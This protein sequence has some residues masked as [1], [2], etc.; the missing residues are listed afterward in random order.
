MS[1]SLSESEFVGGVPIPLSAADREAV[2]DIVADVSNSTKQGCLYFALCNNRLKIESV[3]AA[4]K[5][6]LRMQGFEFKRLVLAER[7]GQTA[8]PS[9]RILIPDP[10]GYFAN[11]NAAQPTLFLVHG[12]PELVR[13]ETATDD[14]GP[15][16][17]AQRL[18]YGREVFHHRAI[19][20]LF[21]I[22][23]ETMSYLMS[24]SRDFWSFRS[25]TAQFADT[26]GEADVRSTEGRGWQTMAPTTRWLGDLEEKLDQLAT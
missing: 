20:A 14:S 16:P 6:G 15:A 8:P 18:N 25:G 5:Q 11:T 17:V 9:Y 13:A 23:L 1:K 24:W 4:L 21:W 26:P 2:V 3:E 12:L 10:V 22:D 19:C 7:T